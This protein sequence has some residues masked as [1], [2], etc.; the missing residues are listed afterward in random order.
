M[1][2]L[3]FGEVFLRCRPRASGSWPHDEMVVQTIVLGFILLPAQPAL[4]HPRLHN[5]STV[6]I[7]RAL[8]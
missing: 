5:C 3:R 1:R 7:G 2:I 8:R 4:V 6:E